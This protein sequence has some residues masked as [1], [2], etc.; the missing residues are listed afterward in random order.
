MSIT[1]RKQNF[2]TDIR[3]ERLPGWGAFVASNAEASRFFDEQSNGMDR[4]A[5][6]G[7]LYLYEKY[8]DQYRRG[9][10]QVNT[11]IAEQYREENKNP[12]TWELRYIK[13]MKIEY[14]KFGSPNGTFYVFPKNPKRRPKVPYWYT[15]DELIEIM[16]SGAGALA[17]AF[18]C[19]PARPDALD[20]DLPA[21]GENHVKLDMTGA[22]PVR[23]YKRWRERNERKGFR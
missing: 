14:I 21:P 22:E 19:L 12:E 4:S 8:R 9:H 5:E 13:H 3:E 17:A 20:G 7:Q 10:D 15:V 23:E 1:T 2:L 6:D 16:V 11:R 18:D